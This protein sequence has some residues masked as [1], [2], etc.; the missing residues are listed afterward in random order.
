M[1]YD[2]L[3]E[4]S[5]TAGNE[6]AALDMRLADSRRELT[7]RSSEREGENAGT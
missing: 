1:S 4:E 5:K 6:L 7:L 3:D 2:K